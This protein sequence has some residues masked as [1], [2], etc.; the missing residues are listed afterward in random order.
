MA[1]G[2]IGHEKCG[3]TKCFICTTFFENVPRLWL[4]EDCGTLSC[5]NAPKLQ[6]I[7]TLIVLTETGPNYK[8]CCHF[9]AFNLPTQNDL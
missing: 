4:A 2:K 8:R 6:Q 3:A 9:A 7:K 5:R 1:Q